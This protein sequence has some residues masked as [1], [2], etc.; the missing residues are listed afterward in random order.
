MFDFDGVI[1][2]SEPLHYRAFRDVLDA[3]GVPFPEQD[4]YD[5]YLGYDDVGVFRAVAADRAAYPLTA[6]MPVNIFAC[7]FWPNQPDEPPVRVSDRG[8]SNVLLVQNLRDP[9]TPHSGALAMRDALGDR[10]RMVTVDATGHGSYVKTGNACG[11]GRVTD[12]L[13]TGD[14]P[15]EDVFCPAA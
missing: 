4:Y 11:D 2:N 9:A 5:R 15:D 12:F 14:R 1:A 8:P 13:L 3:A 7:A 10:A 6:G